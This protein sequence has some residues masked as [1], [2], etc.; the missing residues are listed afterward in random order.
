MM[1]DPSR[2]LAKLAVI[3][4]HYRT[5]NVGLGFVQGL[6]LQRGAIASSV[7]HDSHIVVVAGM[8]DT[9]MST[10]AKHISTIA[11]AYQLPIIARL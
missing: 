6:D 3:E 4:R 5:G 8:N 11:E 7:A 10:A 2:D 9:D 1:T